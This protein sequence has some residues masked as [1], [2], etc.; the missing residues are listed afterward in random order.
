M[1]CVEQHNMKRCVIFPGIVGLALPATI[2]F[3]YDL[4]LIATWCAKWNLTIWSIYDM[5]TKHINLIQRERKLTV[6][7]LLLG[8]VI[9][10]HYGACI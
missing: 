5:Y 10:N 7:S 2:A 3:N 9:Y 4:A 1:I 8:H 6:Y